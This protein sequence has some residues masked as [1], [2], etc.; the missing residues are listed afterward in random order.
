MERVLSNK[1]ALLYLDDIIVFSNNSTQ[2]LKRLEMVFARLRT[3]KLRL[4]PKKCHLFKRKVTFLGHVVSGDGVTTDPEKT[5]AVKSWPTPRTVKAVRAFLGLT[6]Y[7][8][9]FIQDYATIAAPMIELTR[10]TTKFEWTAE[11]QGAFDQLKEKLI[12]SPIL[13]YLERIGEF[14]L[15]TDASNCSI[16][17]VLSHVQQGM[18]RVIAYGS[19]ML[20][21]SE[22]NYCVTRREFWQQYGS[23][24]I[25]DTI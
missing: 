8:R 11:R 12:F 10:K 9:K 21:K 18:E 19:R 16:G 22:R 15:Y 6:G 23:Q 20:S 1:V 14:I 25:L 2:Q 24:N 7:N 13:G 17:A 3:A 5:E 4:K